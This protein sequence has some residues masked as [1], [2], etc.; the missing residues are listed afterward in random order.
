MLTYA[1]ASIRLEVEPVPCVSVRGTR[2]QKDAAL[3][4]ICLRYADVC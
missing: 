3:A 1:G 2:A 4:L